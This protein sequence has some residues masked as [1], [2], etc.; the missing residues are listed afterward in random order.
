M[1]L[2]NFENWSNGELSKTEHHFRKQNDLK[3]GVLK[4]SYLWV[5][6]VCD[7]KYRPNVN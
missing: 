6:I 5:S 3:I 1:K 2:L 4:K 7:L